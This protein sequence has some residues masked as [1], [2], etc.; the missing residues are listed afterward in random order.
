[1]TPGKEKNPL[2]INSGSAKPL[3]NIRRENHQITTS[4]QEKHDQEFFDKNSPLVSV[5][6]KNCVAA[7]QVSGFKGADDE[8]K[9]TDPVYLSSS[10]TITQELQINVEQNKDCY[11]Q[12]NPHLDLSPFANLDFLKNCGEQ[13]F[14]IS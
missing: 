6:K 7:D 1:M 8:T 12:L 3:P 4:L 11:F 14:K 2:T 5:K 10:Q 13:V 9:N